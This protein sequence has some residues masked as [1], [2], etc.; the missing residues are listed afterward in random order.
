MLFNLLRATDYSS[1]TNIIHKNYLCFYVIITCCNTNYLLFI[2]NIFIYL[3]ILT[4]IHQYINSSTHQLIIFS[5]ILSLSPHHIT[6][7][8][9]ISYHI[10]SYHIISHHI[11]SYRRTSHRITPHHIT[12]H[13]NLLSHMSSY[14]PHRNRNSRP[15]YFEIT[16]EEETGKKKPVGVFDFVR[17]ASIAAMT[18]YWQVGISYLYLYI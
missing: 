14:S 6:S 17:N 11:I 9:I 4:P 8:H 1:F 16:E 7:Y 18:G 5:H 15:N 13:S 3:C 12:S 10:I 2:F